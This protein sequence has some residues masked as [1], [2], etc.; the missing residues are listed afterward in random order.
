MQTGLP[1]KWRYDPINPLM[2]NGGQ[3]SWRNQIDISGGFVRSQAQLRV[4]R[5]SVIAGSSPAWVS[6]F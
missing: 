2:T 4:G 1:D 3:G 5:L 6:I